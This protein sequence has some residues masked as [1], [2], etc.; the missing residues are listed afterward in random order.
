MASSRDN[1]IIVMSSCKKIFCFRA[2]D[3][4]FASFFLSALSRRGIASKCLSTISEYD[5]SCVSSSPA[6]LS[7]GHV[8]GGMSFQVG[9]F[10]S[11]R[12]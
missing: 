4:I 8:R 3:L 1:Q 11:R 12:S 10:E 7:V 2:V 6:D 9:T 5:V